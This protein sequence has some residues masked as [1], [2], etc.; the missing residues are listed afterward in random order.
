[1][2]EVSRAM[3]RVLK[4]NKCAVRIFSILASVFLLVMVGRGSLSAAHTVNLSVPGTVEEMGVVIASV[5]ASGAAGPLTYSWSFDDPTGQAYFFN[6][7]TAAF[8]KTDSGTFVIFGVGEPGPNAP[9]PSLQGQQFTVQV[10]V[11]D[12]TDTVVETQ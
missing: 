5:S 8:T 1:M 2:E 11:F 7:T 6:P 3:P 4:S 12:G 10:S 9:S